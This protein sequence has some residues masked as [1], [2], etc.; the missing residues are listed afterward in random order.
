MFFSLNFMLIGAAAVAG[1]FWGL[2]YMRLGRLD[3]VIVSHS[4]WSAVIFAVAP[5][6]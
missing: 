2:L 1:A 5:M 3:S 4:L 6:G